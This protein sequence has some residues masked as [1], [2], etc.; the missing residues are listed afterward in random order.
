MLQG[1]VF[2]TVLHYRSG[3]GGRKLGFFGLLKREVNCHK[4]NLMF[5]PFS[6]NTRKRVLFQKRRLR[7]TGF[8]SHLPAAM[9]KVWKRVGLTL[10]KGQVA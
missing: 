9:L 10:K 8:V 7:S 5:F 1:A 4:I 3:G 6:L 2:G